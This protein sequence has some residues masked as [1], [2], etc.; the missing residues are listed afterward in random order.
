MS[1]KFNIESNDKIVLEYLKC[2]DHIDL[3][4]IQILCNLFPML[5][6]HGLEIS[7]YVKDGKICRGV[8]IFSS[9]KEYRALNLLKLRNMSIC[10]EEKEVY[11][12]R[13]LLA[14]AEVFPYVSSEDRT[15]LNILFEGMSKYDRGIDEIVE[16]SSESY[17]PILNYKKSYLEQEKKR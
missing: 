11:F 2:Y 4:E 12:W 13:S 8:K 6:N 16:I 9:Q 10:S 17:L 5:E 14:F 3:A 1:N 15:C 7:N